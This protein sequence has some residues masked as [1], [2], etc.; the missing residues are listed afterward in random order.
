MLKI[1][2]SFNIRITNLLFIKIQKFLF[3]LSKHL[4][5]QVLLKFILIINFIR[6]CLE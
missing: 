6:D 5:K 2:Y 1:L 4:N 3:M